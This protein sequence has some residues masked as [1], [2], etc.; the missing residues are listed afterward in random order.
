MKASALVRT[1]LTSAFVLL[2]LAAAH[3]L[4]VVVNAAEQRFEPPQPKNGLVARMLTDRPMVEEIEVA[5]AK[6]RTPDKKELLQAALTS[7]RAGNPIELRVLPVTSFIV[8]AAI[9]LCVLGGVLM[10]LTSRLA[11]DAAQSILGIF[12]GNLIWTG[13]IE[14][15]LTIAARTFGLGKVVGVVDGQVVAMYGEYVLLKHTWGGILL[16][17]GYL[18]FLETSRCPVFLWW[19]ER[20]PT[21]R[22]AIATG[23]IDNYGPRSA[24]QYATTSWAFYL[25]LLWAYDEKVFGVYGLFTKGVLFASLAGSLYCIWRLYQQPSWGTAVR[26]A[27]GAMIVVWTPVEIVGKW[28][29]LKEPWLLLKAET[30]I[31][32][33]GGLALGTFFLW[34]AQRKPPKGTRVAEALGGAT[35]YVAVQADAAKFPSAVA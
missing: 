26:Y 28:G 12:A 18:V 22:G 17:L 9:G 31:L 11:S 23:R 25:L 6:A 20:V 15:G 29:L 14:Y 10:W 2:M 16:I 24:F 34:R 13:G 4:M 19:R 8:W 3:L 21:M 27:V 32:F 30:L 7:A 33:F 5:L 1:V 35:G